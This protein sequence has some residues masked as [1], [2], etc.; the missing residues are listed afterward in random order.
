MN[1]EQLPREVRMDIEDQSLTLLKNLSEHIIVIGGWAV[2]ALAGERHARTTLDVDG[3][4]SAENL[5]MVKKKI[6]ELGLECRDADW[7]VQ[8]FKNYEPVVEITDEDTRKAVREVELRIE[9][10]SN[11]IQE[12]DSHHY[13]EFD[14]ED[15]VI[16]E[17]EFHNTDTTITLR[18]PPARTMA[19]A[20]LGLPA[21]Y[22]NNFDAA[23]L[24][25]ICEVDDMIA[26]IESTDDWRE[27]VLRRIPKLRGRMR[28]HERLENI[29]SLRA[30]VDV[31]AYIDALD[32]IENRLRS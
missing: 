21:D 25:Q 16:K 20:K 4:A 7:G 15:W 31:D 23:V 27:M 24:L 29:L 30:G 14:L 12:L 9:I 3:V 8:L 28:N 22:K 1:M 6:E 5:E 2:R 26:T 32:Y 17:I 18:V 11:R 10:S 19:A 13:F